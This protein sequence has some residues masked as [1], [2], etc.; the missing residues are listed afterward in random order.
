MDRNTIV[1]L[2]LIAG[3]L[4]GYTWLTKPSKRR[5]GSNKKATRFY[6]F[7]TATRTAKN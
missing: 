2:V 6:C 3:I 5:A 1:G 4:I 7:S